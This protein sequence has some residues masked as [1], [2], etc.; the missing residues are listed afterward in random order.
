MPLF[1][2]AYPFPWQKGSGKIRIIIQH[3]Q[4]VRAKDSDII[5]HCNLFDLFFHFNTFR[6]HLSKPALIIMECRIRFCGLLF[7]H[8]Q[9]QWGGYGNHGQCDSS[10]ISSI[11]GKHFRPKTFTVFWV[12][13][14]HFTSESHVEEVFQDNTGQTTGFFCGAYDGNRGGIKKVS[15]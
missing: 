9:Y 11:E 3:S 1:R 5:F 10:G 14:I 2:F 7:Q 8:I 12:Y 4:A 13:R 15:M 6:T